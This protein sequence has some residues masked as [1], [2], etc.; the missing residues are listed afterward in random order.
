MLLVAL[1][2]FLVILLARQ[3][4]QFTADENFS[5]PIITDVG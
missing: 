1:V 3:R 5:S 2:S 4:G